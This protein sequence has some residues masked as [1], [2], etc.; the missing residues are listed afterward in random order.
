[1]DPLEGYHRGSIARPP[2][3][4]HCSATAS[5]SATGSAL[6]SGAS[7]TSERTLC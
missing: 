5:G 4:S 7:A 3:D 1:M 2:A 6:A